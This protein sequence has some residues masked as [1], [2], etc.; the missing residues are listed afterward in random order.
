MEIAAS[1]APIVE[2]K[3][4]SNTRNTRRPPPPPLQDAR[5][6]PLKKMCFLRKTRVRKNSCI[7]CI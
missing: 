5:Q 7:L 3:K 2:M 4:G 6:G 1:L